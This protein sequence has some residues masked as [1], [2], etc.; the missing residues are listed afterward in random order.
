MQ[1]V[2]RNVVAVSDESL[3]A[4]M[5]YVTEPPVIKLSRKFLLAQGLSDW[6]GEVEELAAGDSAVPEPAKRT[7]LRK[8]CSAL[9]DAAVALAARKAANKAARLPYTSADMLEELDALATEYSTGHST[10]QS[11][12]NLVGVR[13]T[14]QEHRRAKAAL[15]C[16]KGKAAAAEQK[17]AAGLCWKWSDRTCSR[18]DQCRCQHSGESRHG[19]NPP[20][21]RKQGLQGAGVEGGTGSAPV[22]VD[23][24]AAASLATELLRMAATVAGELGLP[25][26]VVLCVFDRCVR[27][28][29][30]PKSNAGRALVAGIVADTGATMG[31]VYV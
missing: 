21:Y 16:R 13:E 20:F 12:A 5:A 3:E 6:R 8:M 24:T 19:K 26:L 25:R 15:V 17:K 31:G 29:S 14:Q 9:P 30:A 7:S 23:G 28:Y 10:A 27:A 2:A 4:R 11:V 18:G 1:R 22:D